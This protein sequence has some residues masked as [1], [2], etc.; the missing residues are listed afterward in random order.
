[1]FVVAPPR[2]HTVQAKVGMG[3]PKQCAAELGSDACQSLH[4]VSYHLQQR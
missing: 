4:L 1:M 3:G 2:W